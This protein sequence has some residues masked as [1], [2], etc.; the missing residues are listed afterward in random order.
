[1]IPNLDYDMIY[2]HL[3]N[4][5]ESLTILEQMRDI[6]YSDLMEDTITYWAMERGLERCIQNVLDIGS[7]ILA[8]TGAELPSY[9][10]QIL[11]RLGEEGIVPQ[12]F[13]E[14]IAPMAG[15][16]NLLVHEYLQIDFNKTY[17]ILQN[18]LEDFRTFASYIVEFLG[19]N[20]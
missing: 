12:E 7:H 20:D 14:R 13:A 5:Q 1:M 16:R 18:H 15:F 10:R 4:I 9:Y 3:R 6:P 8:S 17:E 11:L 2:E 19:A